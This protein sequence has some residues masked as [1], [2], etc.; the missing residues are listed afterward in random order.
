MWPFLK[1]LSG[2]LGAALLVIPWLRDYFGRTK[3]A[4]LDG[5]SALGSI[6]KMIDEL[7]KHD[8][9]WLARPKALGLGLT[10]LGLLL[11]AASFLIGMF[12]VASHTA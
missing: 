2:F 5:V 8:E 7:K 4:K 9:A 12:L 11:L 6:A 3:A 1:E 10:V